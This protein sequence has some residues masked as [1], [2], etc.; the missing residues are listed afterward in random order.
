MATASSNSSSF[1]S[2]LLSLLVALGIIGTGV[3]VL[4]YTGVIG[5]SLPSAEQNTLAQAQGPL[6]PPARLP[7]SPQTAPA[8]LPTPEQPIQ[9]TP[10]QAQ[11]TQ[12]TAPQ[13]E[14]V[15]QQQRQAPT[16]P[17]VTRLAPTTPTAP[18][19]A[20]QAKPATAQPKGSC[21]D[22]E[23]AMKYC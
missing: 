12:Q 22:P 13:P 5:P 16:Q 8:R 20:S 7:T 2:F 6:P 9:Q 10:P 18:A 19:A 1:W 23:Y 17:V 15:Q 21:D 11:P 4:T 3:A 14:P